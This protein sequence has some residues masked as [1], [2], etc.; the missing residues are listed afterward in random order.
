VGVD[1]NFALLRRGRICRDI[2]RFHLVIASLFWLPF[3]RAAFDLVYSQGVLHHTFS[4]KA[5]FEAISP[6]VAAQGYI[7]IWVY[8]LDSHLVPKGFKGFI[9]RVMWYAEQILRPLLSRA[10]AV[11]RTAFFFVLTTVL[12]PMFLWSARNK[13]KWKWQNTQHLLRDWLSPRYAHRQSYN[14]VLEW[15]EDGKFEVVG[16]QSPAAYRRL[17]GK[18]LG[19][20]G[21]IG[22]RV[23]LHPSPAA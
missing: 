14:E 5:A 2:P 13:K 23:P 1:L 10:P 11:V 8:S 3:R 12:N 19:G 16:V 20:I 17:F 15:F 22:H 18:R 4:T 21:V 9:F 6:F 7:F